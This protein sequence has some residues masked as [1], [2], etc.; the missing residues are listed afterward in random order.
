M[1]KNLA[2]NVSTPIGFFSLIVLV[3]ESI[4]GGLA[5]LSS[6]EDKTFIIRNMIYIL[7]L[8][9]LIVTILV[10]TK[11]EYFVQV[12]SQK[13]SKKNAKTLEYEQ[14][15]LFISSPMAS[16][17]SDEEYQ[18]ERNQM[19]ELIDLLEKRCKFNKVF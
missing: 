15:D 8:V 16:F 19:L 1:L 2:A 13:P 10:Y 9:I 4:L 7:F 14:Y 11:Q 12:N 17:T 6:P 3:V 18:R 5:L